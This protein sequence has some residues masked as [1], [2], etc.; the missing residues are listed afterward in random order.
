MRLKGTLFNT[1]GNWKLMCLTTWEDEIYSVAYDLLP[2]QLSQFSDRFEGRTNI[3]DVYFE[4]VDEFTHPD[5]FIG[6]PIFE[7]KTYAKLI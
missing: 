2:S 5:E 4:V 6:V 1:N 3:H 7:G